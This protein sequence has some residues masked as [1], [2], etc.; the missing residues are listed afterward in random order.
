MLNP[1]LPHQRN[2]VVVE[3]DMQSKLLDEAKAL[4]VRRHFA[5][6]PLSL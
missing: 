2:V 1:F 4:G 3:G 6:V 5:S